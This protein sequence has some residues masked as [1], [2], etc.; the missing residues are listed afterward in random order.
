[1]RE[2]AHRLFAE[3][4]F[5]A[6]TIADIA[7][8]ADVAV[9]T[10]FNHFETK[11]S[12][13]FDGRT[14][15]VEEAAAAVGRRE[16]GSDPVTAL[17]RYLEADLTALLEAEARPENRSYLEALERSSSLRSRERKLVEDAGGLIAAE[18]QAAM[19][20]GDW[21][22]VAPSDPA[23]TWLLSRMTADLFL[24]AGR[25]LAL[26]NRRMLL[27]PGPAGSGQVPVRAM[28]AATLAELEECVRGLAARFA[29]QPAGL[30]PER[31]DPRGR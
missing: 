7:A 16:P 23:T 15:W 24:T 19:E 10:V 14:P 9:Q 31:A 28:T 8:A 30:T 25:V 21:K 3:R 11:E 27:A 13:F 29:D 5:D 1:M 6:V 20:A 4:G 12:L 26:E 18:L 22:P 2:T 17:R